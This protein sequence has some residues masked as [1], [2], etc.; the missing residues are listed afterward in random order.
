M[1]DFTTDTQI[2]AN[3]LN[4]CL[5]LLLLLT[6]P[7]FGFA[8]GGLS[9]DSKKAAKLYEKADK[10]YK[11]RDF[12]SAISYLEEASAIDTAFFEAFIRM[13]SLYNAMGQTDS[14]Y[15]K[16]TAYIRTTPDPIASVL[17]RM[18]F[19][20]FD[21]GAYK[22]AGAYL[23]SFLDKVPEKEPD[24]EIQLLQKSL[25]FVEE[26]LEKVDSIQIKE[27]PAA[28]NRYGLQYLPAI[29]VD[30]ATMIYT[31]RDVFS[32]DEDIVISKFI[33]GAWQPSVPVS[34]KINTPLNEG[35]CTISADGRVMIFTSCDRRDAYGSCDLF[36][37]KKIGDNWSRPKN[38][39]KTV[40]SKYWESQPS[41]SADG[42]T[43]YFTSNRPGGYGGRDI[44]VTVQE[45]GQW[46]KPRN[47]GEE[48]NSFKDETT[49][50]V[51]FNGTS[52]YFSSNSYPGMGGFDL[53][54]TKKKDTVWTSP[55]N[56]GYPINT[57]RDE[58]SL[59][60]SSE[61]EMA[62][63]AKEQ[64]KNR[65]IL[66][67][68]IVSIV[69]PEK[70]RPAKSTYIVG[71][72]VDRS[73]DSPLKAAIEVVDIES[74]ERLYV[75]TSDSLSGEYYMVLPSGK[76]LAGYVK[77]KGYLF[78]EL[79]FSTETK[80]DTILIQL[81]P[82]KEGETLILKN[83]YFDTDAYQLD[84][85]SASEIDNIV[86]LLKQN[87]KMQI[88]ISGHTDDI[89]TDSYNLD[90]S[91]KRALEVYKSITAKG[92]NDAQVTYVGYGDSRPIVPNTTEINRQSNRRIEFRVL[93][94]WQ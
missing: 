56:M 60:V 9:T 13:G 47:L 29:T 42:K 94:L 5:C 61:G 6:L 2:H 16:F 73:N 68:K 39:G 15:A 75:N 76:D 3:P 12:L 17:E 31:K 62:F 48:V 51:H 92:I 69:L 57:F 40:N 22:E 44:W 80:I 30:N 85:R 54:V 26:Q 8:Q 67:S 72:V 34:N 84:V 33:N 24:N 70:L 58:V 19:M 66:D 41:L 23:A 38:L 46:Q 53:F 83:I 25:L 20:A 77:K 89:G 55:N 90:L 10:K 36:I 27:L 1:E 43:L 28:I 86:E 63:F 65:E 59:L 50:F 11:E 93:R 81:S 79:S 52:L 71:K 49:P 74:N 4:T 91:R 45:D 35:A 87:P 18:A 82:I 88:E 14:V 32:S 37:S 64:Q 78:H 21:R 7:V